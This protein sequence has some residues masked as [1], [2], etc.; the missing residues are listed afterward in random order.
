[1]IYLV[2]EYASGGEIFGKGV[3]PMYPS[4]SAFIFSFGFS[5]VSK[6]TNYDH[7]N[8]KRLKMLLK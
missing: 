7:K 5:L 1:M 6:Y 4:A 8:P 2:T 3:S